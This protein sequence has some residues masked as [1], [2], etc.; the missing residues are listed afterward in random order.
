MP[1]SQLRCRVVAVTDLTR[2]QRRELVALAEEASGAGFEPRYVEERFERYPFVA[3]GRDDFGLAAFELLDVRM[4]EGD[5]LVYLGPLFSRRG[6]Y[7]DLF[8]FCLERWIEADARFAFGM[9]IENPLVLDVLRLLLPRSARTRL[10]GPDDSLRALA[11]RFAS[12]FPHLRDLDEDTMTT[13][14]DERVSSRCGGARY[15]LAFVSCGGE[16]TDRAAL[17]AELD[18]GRD[19]LEMRRGRPFIRT[20][21]VRNG[22]LLRADP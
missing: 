2:E 10:D 16:S 5:E 11:R 21:G 6:A 13:S 3:L 14:I 15:R 1:D 20:G 4:H 7:V 18:R 12:S 19:A 8:A 9:E 17:R 22:D